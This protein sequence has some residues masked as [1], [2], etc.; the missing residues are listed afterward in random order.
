MSDF[1]RVQGQ[2]IEFQQIHV[3]SGAP[4]MVF[5][6]EGL[7]SVAMWLDFPERLARAA[8]VNALLYSRYGY[9]KSDALG[10]PR[11][12]GYLHDEALKTLPELLDRLAVERPIL[13]GHSDGASIAL[14][15]AGSHSPRAVVAVAPHVFVEAVALDGVRAI[16]NGYER[17]GLR[18]KLAHYHDDPDS[19]FYGWNDIW[20]S[21]EFRDWCIEEALAGIECPVLAVQGLQDEY[22][23]M[24]QLDRM[25]GKIRRLETLKMDHCRHSPHRDQPAALIDATVHFCRQID[26]PNGRETALYPEP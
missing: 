15:Y 24:Q 1:L 20:G 5:L 17:G 26:T 23:T 7:G 6:H 19:A 11:R 12:P 16:R 2:R 22:A 8:G 18:A 3:K 4:V 21:D 25:A 14:L 13:F 9:G 10:G